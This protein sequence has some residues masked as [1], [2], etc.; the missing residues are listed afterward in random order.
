MS[1]NKNKRDC[2]KKCGGS[3]MESS[4]DG[5]HSANPRSSTSNNAYHNQDYEIS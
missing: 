3:E 2:R 4:S 5:Q 1:G